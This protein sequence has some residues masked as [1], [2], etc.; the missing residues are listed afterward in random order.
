MYTTGNFESERE[1][2]TQRTQRYKSAI[3]RQMETIGQQMGKYGKGILIAGGA[4]VVG[5]AVYATLS[6][7]GTS[8]KNV[9]RQD[10]LGNMVPVTIERESSLVSFFKSAIASFLLGLARERLTRYLEGL[11]GSANAKTTFTAPATEGKRA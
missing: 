6:R 7:L 2:L 10:A 3:T 9:F 1:L 4:L 8:K 5:Y 11:Q